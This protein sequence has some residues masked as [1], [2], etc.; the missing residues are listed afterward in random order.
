MLD[1][2]QVNRFIN[3]ML[4]SWLKVK[5]LSWNHSKVIAID[6]EMLIQGRGSPWTDQA[7]RIGP[8]LIL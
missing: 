5:S 2:F 3:V 8:A 1:S 6:G 7:W 4:G